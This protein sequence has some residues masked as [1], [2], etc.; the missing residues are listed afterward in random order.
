MGEYDGLQSH[1]I[2]YV[3]LL[4]TARRLVGGSLKIKSA[5]KRLSVGNF[6]FCFRSLWLMCPILEE[7][8]FLTKEE[9]AFPRDIVYSCIRFIFCCH[10]LPG[11]TPHL[12]WWGNEN[13]I[14]IAKPHM[15]CVTWVQCEGSPPSTTGVSNCSS[16]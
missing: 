7:S 10:G 14:H 16:R 5:S 9:S 3:I 4:Y 13:W 2:E 15:H 12:L 1:C 6:Y 8:I 11:S